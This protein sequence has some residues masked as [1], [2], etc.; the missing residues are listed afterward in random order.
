MS[1]QLL[2]LLKKI[3]ADRNEK[4]AKHIHTTD[5][6]SKQVRE[7]KKESR[8]DIFA[9]HTHIVVE[10]VDDEAMKKKKMSRNSCCLTRKHC[11]HKIF[12]AFD[13]NEIKVSRPNRHY[14]YKL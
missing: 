11:A 9:Y 3:V 14:Y 12:G 4:F 1:Q 5:D 2:C 13:R 8:S 10:S 7:R 6:K